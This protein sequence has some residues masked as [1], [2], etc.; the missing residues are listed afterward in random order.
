MKRHLI[1]IISLLCLT[2]CVNY[3]DVSEATQ[4]KVQ[5]VMPTEFT[6]G[7]DLEGHEVTLSLGSQT[8]SAI[9]DAQGIATFQNIVPDVYNVSTSW[10]ITASQYK[11]LSGETV[12]ASACTVAGNL[13]SQLLSANYATTPLQLPTQV[14]INRDIVIGKIYSAGSKDTNNRPYRAGKY[15]ELYNQSDKTIDVAG[16]YIAMVEHDNPQAYTLTNL[17]ADFADSVVLAAQ[18]FRIPATTP[19]PVAPGGTVLLVNS[20]IDH[21]GIDSLEHN[22]LDADFEAKDAEGNYQN[23][24]A[25]PALENVSSIYSLLSNMNLVQG[26]PCGIIIFR[27]DEDVT[28]WPLTYAYGKTKGT[29]WR[30]IPKRVIIDGVDYL[31]KKA[32]GVDVSTKRLYD[33]IDAGYTNINAIAGWTGEVVYRRTSKTASDGHKILMD[34]NN[35]SN[36]FKVSTTIKPREYDEE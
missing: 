26:G 29:Q 36:D 4:V 35:S 28:S 2:S 21:S 13:N 31:K 33:D 18:V 5:L 30:L 32:T 16:L 6:Q 34:T 1:Y 20:A 24:P 3:D 15:I 27:T 11:T 17:H 7:S 10:E 14:S 22:L 12:T 25:T 19:Y 8:T 9:T 23:N